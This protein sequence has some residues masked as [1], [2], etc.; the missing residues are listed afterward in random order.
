MT[1]ETGRGRAVARERLHWSIPTGGRGHQL[2]LVPGVIGRSVRVVLDGQTVARLS[3][4]SQQHPWREADVT[5]DGETL[6]VALIWHV[7][8]M[9]TDVFA[10]GRSL[11]DG[12]TVDDAR[13]AAPAPRSDYEVWLRGLYRARIPAK[14]QLITPL[15]ALVALA[16]VVAL[17]F[18]MVWQPRPAGPLAGLVAAIAMVGAALIWFRSWAV[19]TDSAHGWLI[20]RPELGDPVRVLGFFGAF[21]GYAVVSVVVVVLL[22][23]PLVG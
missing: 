6:I 23:R 21:I 8:V 18:L 16:S 5:I 7:P 17:A 15:M 11:L 20:V 9:R 13:Q 1:I 14:R 19:I 3:K 10:G 4:P 2:D 12:R 22:V